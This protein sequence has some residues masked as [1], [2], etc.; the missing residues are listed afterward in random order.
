MIRVLRLLPFAVSVAATLWFLSANPFAAP[1]VER[2][3]G[4]MSRALER[5]VRRTASAEWI[6]TE[7]DAA[8]AAEDAERVEMLLGLAD[9][10]GRDVD[11]GAAE[12]LIAAQSSW[13]ATARSCG[14]CMADAATCPSLDLLAACAVPF[15]LSPL[16]D[17]NA[18]RRA[19]MAWSSGAE[20][21][22]LDAGLAV[23]GLGAT[24]AVLVTGGASASVKAGT[25]LLRLTRRMGTLSPDLSRLLN[26]PVRPAAIPAY[27][28]GAGRLEDVTDM[29]KLATAGAVAADLG[30]VRRATSTAETLRLV[31]LVDRPD[32]AARLA[33]V[34]EVMGPRTARTFDVLGKARVFR[35]T[36]R[37]S[38][39]ATEALLLIWVTAM[40]AGA[41][42]A[43]RAGAAAFRGM[44]PGPVD[45]PRVEPPIRRRAK[46][47]T[48][49][50]LSRLRDPRRPDTRAVASP[51]PGRH[52]APDLGGGPHA[53]IPGRAGRQ[54]RMSERD[55]V[56]RAAGRAY[57]RWGR[58][59][60]GDP[61]R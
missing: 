38:R 16:G 57:R 52:A 21:D 11:R 17:L 1:F 15:E 33:R 25:G 60:L 7:L 36:V 45:G 19:G 26:V 59:P 12:A 34:S 29:A 56:R 4:D 24:G 6:A 40:Q 20:V 53:Q 44:L 61:P 58:D 51:A 42:L 10:L 41:W 23:V 32:D 13:T 50:P 47:V 22:R 46:P 35:A 2:S 27:L 18:L 3:A 55:A 43:M 9:D 5:A 14:T 49:P 54:P 39:A 48:E 28:S 37:L 31:R 8:V 30:R